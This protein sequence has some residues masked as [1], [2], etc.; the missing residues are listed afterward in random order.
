[1]RGDMPMPDIVPLFPRGLSKD[2][3]SSR[4]TSSLFDRTMSLDVRGLILEVDGVRLIDG[5]SAQISGTGRTMIMGP[6]GAGKSLFL[7]LINGL[8][9]PTRGNVFWNDMPIS[10]AL[11][12]R[13]AMVFQ[14]P[15]LLRRSVK[16][17]MDF[18]FRV[19]TPRI[20]LVGGTVDEVRR[21]ALLER[22]GLCG[23]HDQPAR[24]L[25][26]GE[27][28]RLAL[29]RALIKEPD[30]LLLDEA[31][32]S[33]DP[34]SVLM[35]EEIVNEVQ[36]LGTKIIFVTHDLGQAR[37]LGDEIIFMHR[38]KILEQ[39]DADQFFAQPQS[40]AAKDYLAGRIIL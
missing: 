36:A 30:V 6:N 11:R 27:Q 12:R 39:T 22:V 33:L 25:S 31:T 16:D 23:R 34:A 4:P 26:G 10:D 24:L 17:N 8:L 19:G 13:Q 2:E 38:G 14:R 32:A 35:I 28:Q 5:V 20:G 29:A 37:R 9:E 1:M 21:D 3:E 18:A 15:V 7:R 40:E